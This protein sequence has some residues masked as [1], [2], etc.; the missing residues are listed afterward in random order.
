MITL[1]ISQENAD[2]FEDE[3]TFIRE[4][5]SV[6]PLSEEAPEPTGEEGIDGFT[7]GL[8][9]E[10]IDESALVICINGRTTARGAI[11]INQI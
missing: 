3:G 5:P 10:I 7:E 6:E 11:D 2:P 8:C 4:A 9:L 1:Y